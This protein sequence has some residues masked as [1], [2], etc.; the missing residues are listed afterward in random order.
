MVK[1]DYSKDPQDEIPAGIYKLTVATCKIGRAKS[2]GNKRWEVEFSIE[3][4]GPKVK[5]YMPIEG[6]FFARRSTGDKIAALGLDP[7]G[8]ISADDFIGKQCWGKLAMESRVWDGRTFEDPKVQRAEELASY[9]GLF[10]I[11]TPPP[12]ALGASDA[13]D[14]FAPDHSAPDSGSSVPF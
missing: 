6:S 2:N 14:P 7:D 11:D 12:G 10:H 8:D 1:M 4:K 5:D 13:N 3:G 9:C